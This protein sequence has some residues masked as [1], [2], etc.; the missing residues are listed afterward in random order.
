MTSGAPHFAAAATSGGNTSDGATGGSTS[1]FP[2][3]LQFAIS[4]SAFD[5]H[6]GEGALDDL[7]AC[8]GFELVGEGENTATG[9]IG[10]TIAA[11]ATAPLSGGPAAS[12]Q[13]PLS[14]LRDRAGVSAATNTSTATTTNSTIGATIDPTA[15]GSGPT[16]LHEE[17][18]EEREGRGAAA[19]DRVVARL[20]LNCRDQR[21]GVMTAMSKAERWVAARF[22]ARLNAL[23]EKMMPAIRAA[24]A[25]QCLEVFVPPNRY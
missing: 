23:R 19:G 2:G 9:A 24:A 17:N 10:D 15:S 21:D 12:R 14:P 5:G 16:T 4:R 6:A 18:A 13:P 11:T 8:C 25:M 20:R 22:D 7:I 3:F 1:S